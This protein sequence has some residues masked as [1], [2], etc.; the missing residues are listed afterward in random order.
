MNLYDF[1]TSNPDIF[2][3]FSV[4][5]ILFLYYKCPQK[6]HVLQLHSPYNQFT[7]AFAGT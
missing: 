7:F 2:Q 6:E 5:D 3:Q 4:K 1:H